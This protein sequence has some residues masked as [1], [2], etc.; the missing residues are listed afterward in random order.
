MCRCNC[1][2]A[3]KT[4]RTDQLIKVT[5]LSCIERV[6]RRRL[7]PSICLNICSSCF[8]GISPE[9]IIIIPYLYSALHQDPKALVLIEINSRIIIVSGQDNVVNYKEIIRQHVAFLV[10][11]SKV[12]Y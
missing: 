7:R 10:K 5:D 3:I 8:Q 6:C 12:S 4:K 11:S 2:S 1:S 9:I